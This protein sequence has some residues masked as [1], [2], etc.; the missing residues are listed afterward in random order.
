MQTR[1]TVVVGAVT[2]LAAVAVVESIVIVA[3]I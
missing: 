3:T 1:L 2:A